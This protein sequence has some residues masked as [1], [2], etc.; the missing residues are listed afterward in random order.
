M[1]DSEFCCPDATVGNRS[2]RLTFTPSSVLYWLTL[3]LLGQNRWRSSSPAASQRLIDVMPGIVFQADGDV[4]WSMRYLSAG[5]LPLT[6]YQPAELLSPDSTVSYNTI[7][8]PDDLPQVLKSI[9]R[10]TE[11]GQA[12]EVEYRIHTR[13]GEEKWVWEKGAAVVGDQGTVVGLEGFITDITPL[14]QSEAALRQVEQALEA[15]EDLL[16]LVLDSIPQ[17]LFWKDSQG[18]YLGC[19]QAFAKAMGLA[20][21]AD[22]VGG[23]DDDLPRLSAE[24]AAYHSARDRLVMT[25]GMADLHA[26]EPQTQPDG[27]PGWVDCSRLPMRDAQGTVIGV[28][29]TFEDITRQIADQQTLKRREQVLATLAEIQRQLLAWQWSWQERPI[30]QI[31]AALGEI[32]GASRVYYYELQGGYAPQGGYELQGNPSSRSLSLVQRV[33]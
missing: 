19:N 8:H 6:G 9:Q 3:A 23:T 28:L 12:Y 16:E 13:S 2:A 4:N 29:C 30:T 17:P 25:L 11:S 26:I 5:C 24:E 15:R 27:Q 1:Y 14:K 33:E 20:A 22:I 10:A 31:F 7:T 21:P 32:S 18:Y